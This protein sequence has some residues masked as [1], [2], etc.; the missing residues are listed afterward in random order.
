MGT[1][2][3]ILII[4]NN[5]LQIDLRLGIALC[6]S[7]SG[8]VASARYFSNAHDIP[9]LICGFLVGFIPLLVIM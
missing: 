1:L 4:I 8:L 5:Y 7:L 6:I 3:S 9:Q 2:V